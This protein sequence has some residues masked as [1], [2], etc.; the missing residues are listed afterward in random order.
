MKEKIELIVKKLLNDKDL[1]AKFEKNPTAVIEEYIGVDLPDEM[2]NQAIEAIKA[3]I[4]LEQVGDAISGI[5]GLFGK[6]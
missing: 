4:K 3:K 2:V 1:M 6:K 5:A